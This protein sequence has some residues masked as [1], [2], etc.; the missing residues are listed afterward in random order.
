V[1]YKILFKIHVAIILHVNIKVITS[2]TL[3]NRKVKL[4]IDNQFVQVQEVIVIVIV[5]L[6]VQV[7]AIVIVIVIVNCNC[8]L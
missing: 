1:I 4:R 7:I 8:E 6:I 2:L 5:I 3:L